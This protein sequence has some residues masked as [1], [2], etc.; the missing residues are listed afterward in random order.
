MK[1]I[2]F[3]APLHFENWDYNSLDK[4]IGGSETNIIELSWRFAQRGYDVV[5]YAPIH[6]DCPSSWRNTT[7]LPLDAC[8][9]SEEALW[10]IA[11]TTG[12][13]ES[14]EF[15][16]RVWVQ[17]Q[18]I[19]VAEDKKTA[20][21]EKR[22]NKI[23]KVMALSQAHARYLLR[24]HPQIGDRIC[25]SSNGVRVDLFK[26][27]DKENIERNPY[28][29]IY[30][31]SPD[32]GLVQAVLPL[33]HKIME[34]VPE[35]ELHVYYGFD[36]IDKIIAGNSDNSKYY[37]K[38]KEETM[39]LLNQPNVY[40]HGRIGQ[41]ELYREWLS[42]SVWPY[43]S[44]FQETSC[45]CSLEAQAGGAIP[46]TKPL[47]AVGENVRHGFFVNG[48]C[49]S[50]SLTRASL[51]AHT[52]QVLLD[53]DLQTNIRK[54]MMIDARTRYDWERVVDGLEIMLND[55]HSSSIVQYSFQQRHM[56]GTTLN[57]GCNLDISDLRARGAIN[58]DINA[59][60]PNTEW[61]N[62][63]DV[64]ADARSLPYPDKSFDTVILGDIIEHCD[65]ENAKKMIDE[66][67]RVGKKVV[68]T[69][70]EDYREVHE[71]TQTVAN[72]YTEDVYGNH[73]IPMTK[74]RLLNLIDSDNIYY[75]PVSYGFMD[76]HGVIV[77]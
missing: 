72:D 10:I 6:P 13:L 7:W 27:L 34:L 67:I 21:S 63:V 15:H 69:C 35:A 54:N 68:I 60:D 9:S 20:W 51:V 2:R 50:D 48:S 43:Y 56:E 47:W 61:T 18:D 11:R 52:V 53:Q 74:E 64:I 73:K 16:G 44:D 75:E 57:V 14:Q 66:A 58:L 39:R 30:A 76:G 55:W 62:P 23:E 49:Y 36:N 70:P 22:L 25:V 45:I 5:V 31:S 4:R 33:W 32:R 37:K 71:E 26:E 28:K 1:K 8:D 38:L 42:S 19:D 17:L 24:N 41:K 77:R 46:V 12:P 29:L 59:I 65:D 3:L 40:Y